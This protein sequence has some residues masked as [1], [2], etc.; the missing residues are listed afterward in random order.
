MIDQGRN[1][2]SVKASGEMWLIEERGML[3]R[4]QRQRYLSERL[5]YNARSNANAHTKTI[6]CSIAVPK[7]R[8]LHFPLS[9][10]LLSLLANSPLF[11]IL[12][13]KLSILGLTL[14][15][16][17]LTLELELWRRLRRVSSGSP[18]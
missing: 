3:L 1:R 12:C 7:S 4:H 13:L 18:G 8:R 5:I 17:G 6:S 2:E 14:S 15:I 16:L 11:S 10:L 9:R